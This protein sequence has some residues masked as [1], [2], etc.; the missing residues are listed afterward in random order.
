MG[1]NVGFDVIPMPG[2]PGQPGTPATVTDQRC[3]YQCRQCG[4]S[5]PARIATQQFRQHNCRQHNS[6]RFMAP[7]TNSIVPCQHIQH[8]QHNQQLQQQLRNSPIFQQFQ[9]V[10]N[11]FD[12]KK[13]PM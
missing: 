3:T 1:N 8:N 4:A 6:A 10:A 11:I 12:L 7:N 2:G 5:A 13:K 9:Q